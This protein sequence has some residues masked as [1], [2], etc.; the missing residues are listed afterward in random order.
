MYCRFE[1]D[2]EIRQNLKERMEDIRGNLNEYLF[3]FTRTYLEEKLRGSYE[4]FLNS[5]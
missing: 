3:E 5:S 2:Q 4:E 1:D